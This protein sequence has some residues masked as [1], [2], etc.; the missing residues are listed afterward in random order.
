MYYW[1]LLIFSFVAYGLGYLLSM[2][3]QPTLA[4]IAGVVVVLSS[5]QF[6]GPLR[7]LL[8]SQ[9]Y[10][11]RALPFVSIIRWST[12]LIYLVEIKEY[13]RLNLYKIDRALNFYYYSFDNVWKNAVILVSFGIGFRILAFVIMHQ[14]KPNSITNKV[15]NTVGGAIKRGKDAIVNKCVQYKQ[16]VKKQIAMESYVEMDDEV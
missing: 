11:I 1:V 4:Y 5:S 7:V 8:N 2:L 13:D 9:F 10:P 6:V 15:V 14:S 3:F 16:N 12:E